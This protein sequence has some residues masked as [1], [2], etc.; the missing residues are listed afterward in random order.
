M[1]V[2]IIYIV[3]FDCID[4]GACPSIAMDNQAISNACKT[5]NPLWK[6][7]SDIVPQFISREFKF[8]KYLAGV[9][10]ANKIAAIAEQQNHHPEIIIC[11]KMV[12]IRYWTHNANGLTHM[13]FAAA[14][15][16]D[17]L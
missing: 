4:H 13:D 12:K 15:E 17:K 16:I 5:I 14:K 7:S 1:D 2:T 10:F 9:E 6:L 8:D 3:N 11:F